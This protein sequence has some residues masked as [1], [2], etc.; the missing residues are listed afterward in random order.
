VSLSRALYD[1]TK[2]AAT[3]RGMT[4]AHFVAECIRCAGVVAPETG[5]FTPAIAQRAHERKSTTVIN[6]AIGKL[7]IP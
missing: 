4:L 2:L 3:A 7:V 5:H 6:R 1:A